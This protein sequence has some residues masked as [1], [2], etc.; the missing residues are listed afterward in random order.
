MGMD[1]YANIGD[2]Y[3]RRSVWGWHPLATLLT[4]LEPDITRECR[5]WH[6]NDGDGLDEAAST[7]LAAALRQHL[8]TGE[9]DRYEASRDARIAA[10]PEQNCEICDG[11]GERTVK[12]G[13]Q[14]QTCN[15]C[16][17]IG[18][19]PAFESL[20]RLTE[21]DVREFAEFLETCGGFQIC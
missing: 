8:A 13:R 18:R 19:T 14:I 16:E 15:R 9:V 4:E 3:F 5:H 7:E 2:A 10:L 21:Q 12:S 11:T 1:V 20:Y 17:G 6:S